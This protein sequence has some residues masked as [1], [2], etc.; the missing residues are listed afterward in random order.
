MI[1]SPRKYQADCA[2]SILKDFKQMLDCIICWP[3]GSGKSTLINLVCNIILDNPSSYGIDGILYIVPQKQIKNS[4]IEKTGTNWRLP[5]P[6]QNELYRFR[7]IANIDSDGNI[8][9]VNTKQLINRLNNKANSGYIIPCCYQTITNSN[10][11]NFNI[12]NKV[13]D[14]SRILLVCD[15]AHHIYDDNLLGSIIDSAKARGFRFLFATATPFNNNK[16]LPLL[17]WNN[18]SIYK[19]SIHESMN[20]IDD[21]DGRP[22]TPK[23]INKWVELLDTSLDSIAKNIVSN[24]N[25]YNRPKTLVVIPTSSNTKLDAEEISKYCKKI[26]PTISILISIGKNAARVLPAIEKECSG[27]TYHD[28][29]ITCQL[30][31]Y[32]EGTDDPLL[33][34]L[35]D[36][37][38]ITSVRLSSQI[39]GRILRKKHP[40]LMINALNVKFKDKHPDYVD[41]SLYV[42][43]ANSLS[44]NSQGIDELKWIILN[45]NPLAAQF[46]PPICNSRKKYE[47]IRDSILQKEILSE[48]DDEIVAACDDIIK[49]HNE[50][51]SQFEQLGSDSILSIMDDSNNKKTIN[52]CK[53]DSL[54]DEE[55]AMINTIVGISHLNEINPNELIKDKIASHRSSHQRISILELK[56]KA[57]AE[58]YAAEEIKVN[59]S[60]WDGDLIAKWGCTYGANRQIGIKAINKKIL[61]CIDFFNS[62]NIWP[63]KKD[64]CEL[65]AYRWDFSM[66]Y[67]INNNSNNCT[68]DNSTLEIL[69]KVGLLHSFIT[70]PPKSSESILLLQYNNFLKACQ[71]ILKNNRMPL[72]VLKDSDEHKDERKSFEYI[73]TGHSLVICID[74]WNFYEF[75]EKYG[76]I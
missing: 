41:T 51:S 63:T 55:D 12:L 13:N 20:E 46:I 58:L 2:F 59:T 3:T 69:N 72:Q 37:C 24:F 42:K 48:E 49:E 61:Q 18:I 67:T 33:C 38:N 44:N 7:S 29:I 27:D 56:F 6:F 35:F 71:W 43:F 47:D 53:I 31:R 25:K 1:K 5:Y 65:F 11:S 23:I 70:Y 66:A 62:H 50:I 10:S 39:R 9:H 28:I 45:E 17:L 32:K 15:E 16:P 74:I 8:M 34:A 26:D 14:P 4:F 21:S 22:Y 40:E 30:G 36:F 75:G 64:N 54:N 73:K 52:N 19:R 76:N 57:L 60:K 68:Y